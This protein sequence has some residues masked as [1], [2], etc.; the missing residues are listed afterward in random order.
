[1]PLM[2]CRNHVRK[3]CWLINTTGDRDG[4]YEID[5][6]MELNVRDIKVYFT[7]LTSK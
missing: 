1:M 2:L 6:A 7:L 3:H 4:F 5:R